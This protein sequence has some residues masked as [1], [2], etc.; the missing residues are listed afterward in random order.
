MHIRDRRNKTF[1]CLPDFHRGQLAK[2][3]LDIESVNLSIQAAF[4]GASAG[5]VYEGERQFDLVLR[6]E[7][8]NRKTLADVKNLYITGNNGEQIPLQQLATVE[9]KDGPY[10]IQSVY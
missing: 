1:N 8:S 9:I 4:A 10:Q 6:L 3:G 7:N 2:Y 5:I